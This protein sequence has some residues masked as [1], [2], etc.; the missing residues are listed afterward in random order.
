MNTF[1]IKKKSHVNDEP[2]IINIKKKELNKKHIKNFQEWISKP[3]STYIG[4]D[5]SHRVDGTYQSK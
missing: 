1:I 2:R 3:N 4:R 5:M